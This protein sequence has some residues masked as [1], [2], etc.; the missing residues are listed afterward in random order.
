VSDGSTSATEGNNATYTI[1]HFVGIRLV[2]VDLT[3]SGKKVLI[4]PATVSGDAV[5]AGTG[6]SQSTYI[7]SRPRLI[8]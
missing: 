8:H 2:F 3:G 1:T 4:Q 5:L 6:S 7:Y